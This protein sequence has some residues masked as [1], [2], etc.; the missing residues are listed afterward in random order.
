ME[1]PLKRLLGS[2]PD[3]F[4]SIVVAA[5][6][7]SFVSGIGT[8]VGLDATRDD[9]IRSVVA[10]V[11]ILFSMLCLSLVLLTRSRGASKMGATLFVVFLA[12][13][14]LFQLYSGGAGTVWFIAF[15]PV[16]TTTLGPRRGSR[17]SFYFGMAAFF[18]LFAP[19]NPTASSLFEPGTSFAL[20]YLVVA[21]LSVHSAFR[22]EA[23]SQANRETSPEAGSP[24][25]IERAAIAEGEGSSVPGESL[26][27]GEADEIVVFYR[28]DAL[29]TIEKIP[30]PEAVFSY[31]LLEGMSSPRLL[32]TDSPSQ[33][34]L[35]SQ[36]AGDY[37]RRAFS[38]DDLLTKVEAV[39]DV[40]EAKKLMEFNKIQSQIDSILSRDSD[41]QS[42][43]DRLCFEHNL[44][45]RE[46]AVAKCILKGATNKEISTE[47]FISVET[48]KTHVK[49]LLKKCGIN[50][51]IDFIKLFSKF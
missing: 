23:A 50:S 32:G 4:I 3:A 35:A 34:P 41:D 29:A 30:D 51:R 7:L 26:Q 40:R 25:Q 28:T 45:E 39:I 13:V 49:N 44:S 8:L 17:A 1:S 9:D 12:I 43:F 5:F 24:A 15:P 27:A 48:V 47:L 11:Q 33:E 16:A 38:I 18:L 36:P 31:L 42:G 2:R 22:A 10:M 37:E 19:L 21:A 20:V 46:A 6:L 14:C